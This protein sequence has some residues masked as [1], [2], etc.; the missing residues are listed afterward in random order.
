MT[1][2][3]GR[4]VAEPTG[5]PAQ[6]WP[7]VHDLFRVLARVFCRIAF[8]VRVT[9]MQRVPRT[10]PVVVVANHSSLVEPQL[11]Y[12]WLPRRAAFLMKEEL[13]TGLLGWGLRRLGQIAVHRGGANR[14]ALTKAGEVLHSGGI[15][16]V[17]P[18]GMRGDGNVARAEGGAAWLARAHGA[19]I[20]PLATRGTL[21]AGGVRRRFR[22][23]VDMVVG[24]PIAIR[25]GPG[26][27]GLAAGT[28][29]LRQE[30]AELVR[31]VDDRRAHRRHGD[32][33]AGNQRQ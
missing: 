27:S 26:R 21:R 19:V 7:R 17:F 18:E 28:E 10:G 31:T 25:V 33:E 30:L 9:G 23:R 20:V 1:A 8:R 14:A 4:D 6:A 12:G 32:N 29:K 16:C 2:P 13:N 3:V 5:L 11:I 24:E 22:P 15:V